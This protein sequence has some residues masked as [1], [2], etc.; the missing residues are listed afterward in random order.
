M[1]PRLIALALLAFTALNASAAKPAYITA[2]ADAYMAAYYERFPEAATMAGLADARH[3]RVTDNSP[4]ALARWQSV[5]DAFLTL[6]AEVDPKSLWGTPEWITYGFLRETLEASRGTRVCR[7]E[8]WPVNQ[9]SGWQVS[10]ANLANTQPVT[11]DE[12]RR[13]AI[14]RFSAFPRTLEN[15]IANLREGLRLGYSTPRRN[16]GLV[17]EQLDKLLATPVAESP[18]FSP[19]KRASDAAFTTQWT[20]LVTGTIYP[21]ITKYRDFLRDEYHPKARLSIAVKDHPNGVDCYRAAYR[22][23]STLQREPQ[24]VFDLGM[25]AVKAN[26]GRMRALGKELFGTDDLAAIKKRIQEDPENKF[27]TRDEVRKFAEESVARAKAK[28]PE[29]FGLVPKADVVIQ[30]IP[31]Y[32]E[33]TASDSYQRASDD[34]SRPGTYHIKLYQPEQ[35]QRG[36]VERTAFHETYPGHHLQIA[37]AQERTAVHPITRFVGNSGFSEGWARYTE[38]LSEEMK[39]Y[40]TKHG[41]VGRL[42]WPARGMVIDPGLHVLGWTREQAIA[43]ARESGTMTEENASSLVDRVAVWPAQL[44]AYDSGGLEITALREQAEK[45]LGKKFD[46]RKFHDAVLGDGSVTLPML[47]TKIERWIEAQR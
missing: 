14:A 32:R 10:I 15:E 28:V 13:A 6:I 3:D 39:L 36:V 31:E 43:F 27:A 11:N 41:R 17:I 12:Q 7:S 2:L 35:Q 30:P 18:F 1:K 5:Q 37:I 20:A 29:W 4:A 47:R 38:A 42:G 26:E 33:K 16:V 9:M 22:A 8:L 34:G 44:T 46:I 21:A 23:Y 45:A 19:A 40:A 25:R 24:E